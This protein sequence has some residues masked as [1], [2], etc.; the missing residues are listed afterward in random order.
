[1]PSDKHNSIAAKATG[2]IFSLFNVTSAQEVLLGLLQYIQCIVHGLTGVLPFIFAD[3]KKFQFG[4]S[5][6]CNRNCLFFHS[7]YFD[8]RGAFRTVLDLYCHVMGL[9]I[10]NN[11]A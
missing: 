6:F 10:A 8:C 3:S 5:S 11:E 1:M 2:L 9:N 4:S 7:G